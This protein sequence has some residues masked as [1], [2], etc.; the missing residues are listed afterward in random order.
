MKRFLIILCILAFPLSGTAGKNVPRARLL[1]AISEFKGTDGV[2]LV[3]LGTIATSALK[4]TIRISAAGDPDARQALD[5]MN[6]IKRLTIFDYEDCD[7]AT[8]E[9]ISGRISRILKDSE[10]LIEAKDDEDVMRIY[11]VSDDDGKHVSDFVLYTPS[12]CAL[13]CVF[14]KVSMAAINKMIEEND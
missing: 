5:V 9:K 8:Q 7:R 4:A 14:G 13:I 11:G 1:S 3:Q 6:G 12:E 10:L 2:E